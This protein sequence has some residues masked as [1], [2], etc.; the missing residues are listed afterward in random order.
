MKFKFIFTI[1]IF[2]FFST[3]ALAEDLES[4][5]AEIDRLHAEHKDREAA[6]YAVGKMWVAEKQLGA[7]SWEYANYLSNIGGLYAFAD[8]NKEANKYFF[9]SNTLRRE[10]RLTTQRPGIGTEGFAYMMKGK[11]WNPTPA[12]APNTPGSPKIEGL[13]SM[14]DLNGDGK[15]DQADLDIFNNAYASAFDTGCCDMDKNGRLDENDKT[16]FMQFWNACSKKK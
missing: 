16:I 14:A 10:N 12:N 8:M 5:Q 6:E 13:N 7:K 15:C 3:V 11:G 4:V 9:K 1:L 2:S